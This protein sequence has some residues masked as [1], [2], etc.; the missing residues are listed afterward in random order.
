MTE[1]QLA[2]EAIFLVLGSGRDAAAYVCEVG[3]GAVGDVG[4]DIAPCEPL[5]LVVV[6]MS[7]EGGVFDPASAYGAC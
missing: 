3:D 6:E 7:G 1:A 2:S 4:L 5:V